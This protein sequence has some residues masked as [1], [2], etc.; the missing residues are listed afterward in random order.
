MKRSLGSPPTI[1]G[2]GPW[3]DGWMFITRGIPAICEF[4]PNGAGVHAPD[5]YVEL[6]SLIDTIRIFARV[7]VDFLG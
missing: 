6:D 7:I 4:G 5:E 3:N 2:C 1:L